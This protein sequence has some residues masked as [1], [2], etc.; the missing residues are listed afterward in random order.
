MSKRTEGKVKYGSSLPMTGGTTCVSSPF[1]EGWAYVAIMKGYETI[2]VLPA[3]DSNKFIGK[4][5]EPDID[6]TEANAEHIIALWNA[7][8]DVDTE[9]AKRY[10]EHGKEQEV[11]YLKLIA[12]VNKV[13]SNSHI[14]E[15]DDR[16][17]CPLCHLGREAQA[18]LTKLKGGE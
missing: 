13:L 12:F 2:A 5:S 1:G 3:Q 6:T 4:S 10:L 14:P 7:S 9:D 11:K 17:K 8:V 16:C 18:L 15:E